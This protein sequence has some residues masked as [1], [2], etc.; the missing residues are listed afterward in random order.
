MLIK[1]RTTTAAK[2]FQNKFN[3][4]F[5]ETKG[6]TLLNKLIAFILILFIN[7]F[8]IYYTL[9]KS[10]QRGYTWQSQFLWSFFFQILSDVIIFETLECMWLN[11][12]VPIL[13]KDE[14][15]DAIITMRQSVIDLFDEKS[16]HI[17]KQQYQQQRLKK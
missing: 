13:V 5:E 9:L 11:Y 3:E 10:L 14:V 7:L 1:G 12:I 6:Q 17:T 15:K 2:I 4:D 16:N 8:I